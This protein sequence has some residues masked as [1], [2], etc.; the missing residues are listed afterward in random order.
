MKKW[1]AEDWEFTITVLEGEA[2]QCR[3]GFETGDEFTC[4]YEVPAGFC[5]K[6]MAALYALC[7]IVRCGGS[8]RL[9]GSAKDNEIDFPCADGCVRFRLTAKPIGQ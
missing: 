4:R 5:P 9:K 8:F 7:E 1:I 6:T 3:L 2:R